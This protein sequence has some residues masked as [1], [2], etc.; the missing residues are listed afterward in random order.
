M[1]VIDDAQNK[2]GQR[3]Q[4]GVS[5][6]CVRDRR[7]MYD[8]NWG[9]LGQTGNVWEVKGVCQLELNRAFRPL[10]GLHL[11]LQLRWTTFWA[12]SR[13][14]IW[15]DIFHSLLHSWE[16]LLT[17]DWKGQGQEL[18]DQLEVLYSKPEVSWSGLVSKMDLI[19]SHWISVFFK[20]RNKWWGRIIYF[21][22]LTT[23]L[24]STH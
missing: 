15:S 6:T 2:H 8:R 4:A 13:W 10:W 17:I 23:P 7:D 9:S 21:C 1:G 5:L 19:I 20:G 22:S 24:G 14:E 11:L 3:C 18:G 16:L 12:L